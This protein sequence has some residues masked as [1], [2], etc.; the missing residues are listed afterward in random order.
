MAVALRFDDF[1]FPDGTRVW[2]EDESV[3]LHPQ[4]FD[5]QVGGALAAA[6]GIGR[7][8][9]RVRSTVSADSVTALQALLDGIRGGIGHEFGWLTLH[10]NR[11][12]WCRPG[13]FEIDYLDTVMTVAE[14]SQEFIC[15]DPRWESLT[16]TSADLIGEGQR[17]LE[18]S[19]RVDVEGTGGGITEGWFLVSHGTAPTEHFTDFT[20]TNR[21]EN[22]IYNADFAIQSRTAPAA[23]HYGLANGW[24]AES[25]NHVSYQPWLEGAGAP[26]QSFHVNADAVPWDKTYRTWQQIPYAPVRNGIAATTDTVAFRTQLELTELSD[27]WQ[28]YLQLSTRNSATHAGTIVDAA[29]SPILHSTGGGG[30]GPTVT[31]SSWTGVLAVTMTVV[32]GFSPEIRGLEAMLVFRARADGADFGGGKVR[33]W[34]PQVRTDGVT[35]YSYTPHKSVQ[36]TGMSLYGP[37]LRLDMGNRTAFRFEHARDPLVYNNFLTDGS[38][39]FDVNHGPNELHVELAG[40]GLSPTTI[41]GTAYPCSAETHTALTFKERWWN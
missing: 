3:V 24:V 32:G 36:L 33:W 15:P 4:A 2:E 30:V 29:R 40:T 19:R 11:R 34:E 26:W 5:A 7:R 25:Y 38:E 8:R 16:T 22:L 35:T 20:L 10:D 23:T 28:C 9:V 39:F 12:I 41:A 31:G 17:W 14:L 21:Y 27:N 1:T 6:G 37:R 13:R 18:G